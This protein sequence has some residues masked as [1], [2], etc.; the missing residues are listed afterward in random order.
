[1]HA[2]SILAATIL[3]SAMVFIDSTA[4]NVALPVFQRD[5][6]AD[7][8]AV[9]WIVEAYQ[10]FL[11]SLVL[12]GGSLGDHFGRRRIFIIGV[13]AFATASIGCGLAPTTTLMIVARAVQGAA[14]ALLVPS[15]LAIINA[16]FGSDRGRAIGTWSALTSLTLALGPV[17]GGWIVQRFSWRWV[18]YINVPLA[19]IVLLLTILCV[20]E[21][22]DRNAGGL[23]F[24]GAAL[25]TLA[26]GGIVFGLIESRPLFSVAGL[27][28][29]VAFVAYESRARDSLVPL[30]LFRS[31]LFSACNLL[32]LL[33]YA[34]LGGVFFFLPFDLIHVQHYTPSQAGAANLPMIGMMVL[35][36][37]RAGALMDRYGPRPP[38]IVGPLVAAAGFA[39]FALPSIGGNYWTTFFPPSV[40]LG[41][42][43]AI[44]VAPL[45]TAVM[46]AAGEKSGVA[47]GINNAVARTAALIAV[48][49]L[50]VI[51]VHRFARELEAVV[52]APPPVK[53]AV[54][55]QS[56][57]MTEIILPPNAPPQTR[58]EIAQAFVAAFRMTMLIGAVLALASSVVAM[59]GIRKEPAVQAHRLS[60]AQ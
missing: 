59:V 18:F 11:S 49:L 45:T 44:T 29:L 2:R 19:A 27:V 28:V 38:L 55:A 48:A 32:T 14:G 34:A 51:F 6:H 9:Q 39:L 42:G 30:A 8:A 60:P 24:A 22:H 20:P 15:S 47:S 10:L 36:S 43:M 12:V 35:L 7:M 54:L 21:S 50:G 33:L 25:V 40:V 31:R 53:Q 46:S 37:K 1:M 52:N 13:A 17:V 23:D 3:G 56:A 5:L 58:L 16:S 4:V 57:R 41:L 26:L